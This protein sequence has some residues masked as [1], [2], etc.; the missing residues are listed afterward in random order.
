MM[1]LRSSAAFGRPK[2]QVIEEFKEAYNRWKAGK[3]KAVKA[4]ED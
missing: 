2:V 1:A 4:M 3:M